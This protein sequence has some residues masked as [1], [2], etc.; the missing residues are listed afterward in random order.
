MR[1][2]LAISAALL[3]PTDPAHTGTGDIGIHHPFVTSANPDASIGVAYLLIHNHSDHVDRLLAASSPAAQRVEI[4]SGPKADGG[5]SAEFLA[6]GVGIPAHDELELAPDGIHLALLGLSQPL[7]DGDI[8]TLTLIFEKAG[9]MTFRLPVDFD[10][11]A[12]EESHERANHD[13]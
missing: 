9:E 3:L 13:S 4:Q 2:L 8:L 1:I 10:R 12:E 6:D 5:S 11:L 7:Q